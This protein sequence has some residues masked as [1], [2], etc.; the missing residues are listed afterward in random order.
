VCAGIKARLV[1]SNDVPANG[2]YGSVQVLRYGLWGDVCPD[3]FTDNEATVACRMM[4]YSGGGRP[5]AKGSKV[6]TCSPFPTQFFFNVFGM[7]LQGC[8]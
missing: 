2:G 8:R 4:G 1:D 3:D 6:S 7:C 5:Y